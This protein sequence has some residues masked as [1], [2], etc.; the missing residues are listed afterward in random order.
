[1]C[2]QTIE[3]QDTQNCRICVFCYTY[4]TIMWVLF[5]DG[6]LLSSCIISFAARALFRRCLQRG[7]GSQL[8]VLFGIVHPPH[9]TLSV[10]SM[11]S[12]V[13]AQNQ[14]QPFGRQRGSFSTAVQF[15]EGVH[16]KLTGTLAKRVYK[17][18]CVPRSEAS[19]R[20]L[21][22]CKTLPLSSESE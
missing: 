2:Q 6:A 19:S 11:S 9:T 4:F 15:P 13:E 12:I 5:F 14:T 8:S 16:A 22:V 3:N 21:Q 17:R 10:L 18:Q 1:M 7:K 20:I